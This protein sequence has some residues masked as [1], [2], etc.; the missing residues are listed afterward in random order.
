MRALEEY[1]K[2][3]SSVLSEDV[4]KVSSFLNHQVDAGLL[5]VLGQEMADAYRSRHI[6]KIL[7]VEA[8]GIPI[9][10]AAALAMDIPFIYARK[11]KTITQTD[12]FTSAVQSFT[13]KVTYQVSV[14]KEYLAA[15]DR[16]LIVDDI[17]A[18]GAAVRGLI[19]IVGQAEATLVGV[20][21]A[22]EKSFQSGRKWLDSAGI[23]VHALA[24]IARMSAEHGIE[25]IPSD[26]GGW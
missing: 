23:P 19:D 10:F 13:R 5:T 24:R 12:A 22:I 6:T 16:V 20:S 2:R 25:F 21:V 15:T 7:T 14:E 26:Y 1:I 3:K 4:I 9:A 18:E 8:S 17:L 11:S